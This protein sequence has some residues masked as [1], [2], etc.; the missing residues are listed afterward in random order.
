[1]DVITVRLLIQYTDL[2]NA[3]GELLEIAGPKANIILFTD[4]GMSLNYTANIIFKDILQKLEFSRLSAFDKIRRRVQLLILANSRRYLGKGGSG[5]SR[6]IRQFYA[7]PNGEQSGAIRINLIGRE[8]NG[9]V[10]PGKEYEELCDY[11]S[12]AFLSLTTSESGS[13]VVEKVLRTRDIYSGSYIDQLPDLL[14]MWRRDKPIRSV[15]SELIGKIDQ[16][17]PNLTT[18]GHTADGL[19]LVAGPQ[20]TQTQQLPD[21]KIEDIAPTIAKI[22]GRTLQDIDGEAIV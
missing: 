12:K 8:P 1:M 3:I 14:I 5:Y 22:L 15:F 4:L 7:L 18:G 13:S 2:D 17:D 9:I 11:L 21:A 16:P 10:N 20:I 6:K 19:V